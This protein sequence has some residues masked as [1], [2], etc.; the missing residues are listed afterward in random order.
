MQQRLA[1]DNWMLLC[2]CHPA[3]MTMAGCTLTKLNTLQLSTT[4]N[5]DSPM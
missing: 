5:A 2:C 3:L 1:T 4:G